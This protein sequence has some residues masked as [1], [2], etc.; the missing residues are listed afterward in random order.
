[1]KWKHC[2]QAVILVRGRKPESLEWGGWIRCMCFLQIMLNPN[3]VRPWN[4]GIRF[5][6][7]LNG[8]LQEARRSKLRTT[9]SIFTKENDLLG[10]PFRFYFIQ[11]LSPDFPAPKQ[12]CVYILIKVKGHTRLKGK[13]HSFHLKIIQFRFWGSNF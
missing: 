11:L 12:A 13:E 5:I 6:K 8:M 9:S 7:C 4:S 10:N 3:P 2:W 1:M